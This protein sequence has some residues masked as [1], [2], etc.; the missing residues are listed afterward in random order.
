MLHGLRNTKLAGF[1][2][3]GNIGLGFAI[4]EPSLEVAS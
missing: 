1:A 2:F 3:V 4:G